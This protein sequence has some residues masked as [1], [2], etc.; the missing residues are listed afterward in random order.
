MTIFMIIR[1]L[2]TNR[3]LYNSVPL[4]RWKIDYCNKTLD[5][6]IYLANQDNSG[7]LYK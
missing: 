6:K 3:N 5:R 2:F 7:K 1:N 4:G